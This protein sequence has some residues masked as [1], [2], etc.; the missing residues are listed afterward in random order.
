MSAPHDN[1]SILN[2]ALIPLFREEIKDE[3]WDFCLFFINFWCGLLANDLVGLVENDENSCYRPES[4]LS[5]Y[6]PL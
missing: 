5:C 2:F 4:L 6:R 3:N 1:L